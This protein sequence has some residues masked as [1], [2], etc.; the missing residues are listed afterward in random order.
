MWRRADCS[1]WCFNVAQHKKKIKKQE[2]RNGL[3]EKRFVLKQLKY[4]MNMEM[5][6]CFRPQFTRKRSPSLF[7]WFDISFLKWF[8]A[9]KIILDS[10]RHCND[11]VDVDHQCSMLIQTGATFDVY[12]LLI[13]VLNPQTSNVFGS[14]IKTFAK[15]SKNP[16][17]TRQTHTARHS[18]RIFLFSSAAKL[19]HI[20]NLMHIPSMCE[21][22]HTPTTWERS[23]EVDMH[24]KRKIDCFCSCWMHKKVEL[25]RCP[26]GSVL[27]TDTILEWEIDWIDR[28]CFCF[29]FDFFS[30]QFHYLKFSFS[31]CD[32]SES[33]IDLKNERESDRLCGLYCTPYI[34]GR[35]ALFK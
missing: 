20:F 25:Y 26:S 16:I 11:I 4:A 12:C 9:P 29:C 15:S 18:N 1:V 10:S 3:T 5:F 31:R 14:D 28:C 21:T 23:R 13:Y 34:V 33:S 27:R 8:A 22:C 17:I 30:F 7:A 35:T 2:K 32:S 19:Q 6:L 24:L